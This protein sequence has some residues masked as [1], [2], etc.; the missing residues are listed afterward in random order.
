MVQRF[1]T[2]NLVGGNSWQ[3]IG[4]PPE[5]VWKALLDTYHYR[6]T[7]PAVLEATLV[8]DRGN[9][10]IVFL[11]QGSG[12]IQV[13]NYLR[14][15]I[16][17]DRKEMDFC[18]EEKLPHSIKTGWGFFAIRPYGKGNSVLA[19][20]VMVDVGNNLIAEIVKGSTR[21]WMLKVPWLVKKFVEGSGRW[22]YR[23]PPVKSP[24]TVG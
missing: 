13:T 17:A 9:Q 6:R 3:L 5:I 18:I 19:Y 23:Q 8:K 14:L 20:G 24:K 10:R 7:L 1:G 22:L 4:S 11:R 16:R 21:E 12:L 2:A 15:S